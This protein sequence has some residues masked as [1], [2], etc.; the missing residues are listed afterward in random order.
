MADGMS[1]GESLLASLRGLIHTLLAIARTRFA[2]IANELEEQGIWAARI[3]IYVL[4]AALCF[5]FAAGLA[6]A[7]VVVLFW[8]THRL[9]AL[10]AMF[11]LFLAG[12]VGML[13]ALKSALAQRPKVLST[14]LA[15]IDKDE[16]ALSGVQHV[17]R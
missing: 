9:L 10:G 1:R 3:A 16:A 12:A 8:E 6:V 14:L 5:F 2:L 13:V 17:D 4:A 11:A 7:F 15:E